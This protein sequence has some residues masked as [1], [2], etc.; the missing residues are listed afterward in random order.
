[1]K[2]IVSEHAFRADG[3]RV[4]TYRSIRDSG[5]VPLSCVTA[6]VGR[7][8]SGKTN[9]LLALAGLD[10]RA[11][12]PY[13]VQRDWPRGRK[14]QPDGDQI[15]CALD[16]ELPPSER[17]ELVNEGILRPEAV[18]VRVGRT[19]EGQ[20]RV[21]ALSHHFLH[22]G[23]NQLPDWEE[24][25]GELRQHV[26][27]KFPSLLYASA[28]SMLPDR[29]DLMELMKNSALG[30]EGDSDRAEHV[31]L[32][33]LAEL[34]GLRH[35]APPL[36]E[37]AALV[38]HLPARLSRLNRILHE[39][40]LRHEL[41]ISEER[42]QLRVLVRN[43]RS[44]QSV[45]KLPPARRLQLTLDLRIAAAHAR[46][47][48]APILLLDAPG[49]AFKGGLKRQ[50]RPTLFGYSDAG[51]PVVYSS[52]LPFHVELQHP[53]QVLVLGPSDQESKPLCARP[54]RGTELK[55]MAALG[56]QGRSSFRIDQTNLVVEGPTDAGILRALAELVTAS[57]ERS[58]P[59]ELNIIAAGGAFEVAGVSMFLARQGLQV[60]ALFDSDAAGLAGQEQLEGSIRT[61]V[62]LRG[63]IRSLT[64]GDAA[65]LDLEGATI[66][67][68]FPAM[69]LLDALRSVADEAGFQLLE[70]LGA[71]SQLA[72]E[73]HLARRLEKAFHA[74]H[75]RYPKVEVVTELEARLSSMRSLAELPSQMAVSVRSLVAA[76][77]EA[78]QE[79]LPPSA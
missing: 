36:E 66:E 76:L 26:L 21:A 5:F 58:I 38:A 18:G 52:R 25:G 1:M 54:A 49:K 77:R 7:E 35:D 4:W 31:G 40:G 29:V 45:A 62:A 3:F 33:A 41:A 24:A 14:P 22:G 55:P 64:L 32:R 13:S 23:N 16:L 69:L 73:E 30:W 44:T 10:P 70:D 53:E 78:L 57:G 50:L 59:E 19:Y 68:L 48:V 9:L 56:M 51:I 60:V 8:H 2:S 75:L 47:Q 71:H 39:R 42:D 61:E 15:V 28:G 20:F 72:E 34:L 79:A 74:K 46:S 67:D 6:L 12:S 65:G 37:V 27:D 63:T 43:G 11:H 17:D